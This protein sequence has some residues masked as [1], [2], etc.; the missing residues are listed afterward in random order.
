MNYDVHRC[1]TC[2]K[3]TIELYMLEY[4]DKWYCSIQ[5]KLKAKEKEHEDLRNPPTRAGNI[6]VFPRPRR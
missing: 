1:A 6:V 4:N 5:C 2:G 3:V